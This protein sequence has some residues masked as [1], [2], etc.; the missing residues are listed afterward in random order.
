VVDRARRRAASRLPDGCSPV[1]TDALSRQGEPLGDTVM[2][3]LPHRRDR[4]L[5]SA[6]TAGGRVGAGESGLELG[7]HP[8]AAGFR[9]VVGGVAQ[10]LVRQRELGDG[11]L[12][13]AV[14]QQE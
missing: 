7:E 10:I 2:A 14:L 4:C 8:L 12:R 11:P 5:Q 13:L 6:A 1:L 9:G 3:P